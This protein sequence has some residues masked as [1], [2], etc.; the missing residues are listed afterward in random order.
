MNTVKKSFTS[1]LFVLGFAA[2]VTTAFAQT[3]P[4]GILKTPY[5]IYPGQ[6]TEMEVLWQD[7]DTETTN[8]LRWGTDKT[9]KLG[10]VT[11]PEMPAANSSVTY[12]HQHKYTITGLKPNKKYYYEVVDATNGVYGSG[13]FITAPDDSATSIRFFAQGD[14][15][16]APLQ[17][18]ALM[19]AMT[20]F[21]SKPG[22][23][24]YQRLALANG[25]WVSSD[26][27]S[28]WTTQWFANTNMP[29]VR[30][31]TANVPINGC[32]GNHDNT[33]GV[34]ATFPK[35]YPFPYPNLTPGSY[36]GATT[37]KNGN[38][39]YYNLYW[40]YDYGPVHITHVDEYSDMSQG[41]VQYNWV[42]ND[43]ASTTK[44]W[45]ILIYHEAAYSA[46]ADGDNTAVRVFEPLVTQYNVDV[47]FSGHSHNY[48][49]CGAYNAAQ[50]NGDNIALE[51]P[52][53]TSG[54]GGAPIYQ[55]DQTNTG[56]FPHVIT[57]WPSLEFM[58]F[59]VEGK[60]LTMTAYQVDGLG[61]YSLSLLQNTPPTQLPPS[62][63]T[64]TP[65]ETVVL[66]HFQNVSSQVTATVGK[67]V[68]NKGTKTY[69]GDLTIKNNG[70]ALTGKIDVVLDGILNLGTAT[71]PGVG[72]ADNQYDPQ[73]NDETGTSITVT[74]I[75][76]QNTGLNTNVT[77]VNQTG[78]NNGE[79]M[80]RAT[81]KGLETGKSVT[82]PLK[83]SNPT[84]GNITF[85][86]I[87]LQE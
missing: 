65:I 6:N 25:D 85:N 53:I 35:Y 70:P 59:D 24:D 50:A 34:T 14:S 64:L 22:N 57:A 79:P 3:Q 21:Y 31:Y 12:P 37:D 15:R 47:I 17:L 67:L 58:T 20:E 36:K 71:V 74:S 19:K 82:V 32:K 7:N 52:H 76:A 39:Y 84:S 62:K 60:T 48:A 16:S 78:S 63:L 5:L 4:T 75:I 49:R 69:N 27:E 73:A 33:G 42:Q 29:D 54:G 30:A 46:G 86:P 43:L 61:S 38:P 1:L 56:S 9:Y 45:K 13:S 55:V 77:L 18:D 40:S 2:C 68:Y 51:V 28:Y 87:T 26:G 8:T 72:K 80:I 23:Q 11:V 44:P 83:F 81:T 10:S 66:N 41:S